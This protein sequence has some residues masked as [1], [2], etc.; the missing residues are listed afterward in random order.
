MDDWKSLGASPLAGAH[1]AWHAWRAVAPLVL[2][3]DFSADN[4]YV[5]GETMLLAA[6]QQ[7]AVLAGVCS[8]RCRNRFQN[9]RAALYLD[10]AAPLPNRSALLRPSP[11]QADS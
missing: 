5:A 6:R 1:S 8:G 11:V 10:Q 2:L 3:T 7:D 4:E 9:R